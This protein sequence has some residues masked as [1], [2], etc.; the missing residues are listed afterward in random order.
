ERSA[1][2]A[3]L[4]V[5]HA[6]AVLDALL[7]ADLPGDDLSRPLPEEIEFLAPL[8]GFADAERRL[9]DVEAEQTRAKQDQDAVSPVVDNLARASA[10]AA[11]SFLAILANDEYVAFG[12]SVG[13][14]YLGALVE[15]LSTGGF[16]RIARLS[17][18]P[19][20]ALAVQ[21]LGV[22]LSSLP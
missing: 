14:D 17:H 4:G 11:V 16:A 18:F 7:F 2:L 5:D 1:G 13:G 19:S 6:R 22:E 10:A 21:R 9:A 15:A 8:Q 12:T 3:R 20:Q